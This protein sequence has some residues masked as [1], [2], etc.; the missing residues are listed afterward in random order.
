MQP[1]FRAARRGRRLLQE[2]LP[3]EHRTSGSVEPEVLL[4]FCC[5]P[6]GAP[7][8]PGL[9]QLRLARNVARLRDPAAQ[10]LAET[11]PAHVL[12][13]PV[14]PV[15]ALLKARALGGHDENALLPGAA[16][17]GAA[18]RDNDYR[19]AK[20]QKAFRRTSPEHPAVDAL[21]AHGPS[22]DI[23]KLDA[24]ILRRDLEEIP[25]NVRHR[26]GEFP[27]PGFVMVCPQC[28]N[29]FIISSRKAAICAGVLSSRMSHS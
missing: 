19:M 27:V 13:R 2:E 8:L 9:L 7:K 4:I 28:M 5:L 10:H 25:A 12:F 18:L 20:S 14:V 1:A 24:E 15:P 23:V 3:N 17:V 29:C 22:R 26:G 11:F 16:G 6:D 21:P